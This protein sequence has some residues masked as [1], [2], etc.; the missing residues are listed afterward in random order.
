MEARKLIVNAEHG[1]AKAKAKAF[2]PFNEAVKERLPKF[3]SDIATEFGVD[4]K[5]QKLVI[6]YPPT[7]EMAEEGQ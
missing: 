5:G 1:K 6:D 2:Q 7:A 3:L 4:L